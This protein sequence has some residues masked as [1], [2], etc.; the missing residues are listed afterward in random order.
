[1]NINYVIFTI[2]PGP[3][4]YSGTPYINQRTRKTEDSCQAP[5]PTKINLCN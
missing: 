3:A 4:N 5:P 2:K 1:M